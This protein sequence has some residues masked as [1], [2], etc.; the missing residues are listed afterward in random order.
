VTSNDRPAR[1][2]L[3]E[4]DPDALHLFATALS[5]R[6][7]EVTP[8]TSAEEAS[9]LL[10]A[11]QFDLLVTDW[12]LPGKSG[13]VLAAEE[14][15]AGHIQKTSVVVVTAHPEPSG[16]ED[17]PVV[18][19]PVE[20]TPFLDQV[21]RLLEA[22][23]LPEDA[24]SAAIV[25]LVLYATAGSTLSNRARRNLESVLERFDPATYQLAI[26]D[27]ATDPLRAEDDRVVFAPTLV[28]RGPQPG[29]FLG[30]LSNTAAL[31]DMLL[32]SG[33]GEK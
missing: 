24:T 33:A 26:C 15:A 2:L 7:Y 27:P 18:A 20:L 28:R 14:A 22:R 5:M 29:W 3:V 17:L 1:I 21:A 10:R 9:A 30:D 12:D 8:A 25:E 13:A 11:R 23:V 16:V 32:L 31:H 19:K 6:G 4:D